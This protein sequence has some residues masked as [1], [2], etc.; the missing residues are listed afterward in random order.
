VVSPAG[1]MGIDLRKVSFRLALRSDCE[2]IRRLLNVSVFRYARVPLANLESILSS[3]LAIVAVEKGR[4]RGS[5]ISIWPY[6]PI[7]WLDA[8]AADRG[9]SS[10]TIVDDLLDRF[11]QALRSWHVQR[12]SCSFDDGDSNEMRGMLVTRGFTPKGRFMRYEKMDFSVPH[13]EAPHTTL[14]PCAKH[15]LPD[16]CRIEEASFAP[17]WRNSEEML[18]RAI[19]RFP[20]FKVALVDGAVAGLQ[21]STIDA[22]VGR[23]IHLAVAPRFRGLN[24]AK[25]LLADVIRFFQRRR[26]KRIEVRVEQNLTDARCLYVSF[27][28]LPKAP[29][30]EV[31]T[32]DLELR[33][34]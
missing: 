11:E 8:L 22:G 26:V 29:D 13:F 15:D 2:G 1:G 19:D 7:A 3:R 6:P 20:S 16:I 4:L 32:K 17:E 30:R 23:I 9:P 5:V 14:R 24:V 10:D 12:V 33:T 18:M 21:Y 31:L 28:F 27:G 25:S 34:R